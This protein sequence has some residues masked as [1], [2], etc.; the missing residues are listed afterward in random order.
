MTSRALRFLASLA[1]TLALAATAAA[2]DPGEARPVASS[3]A[4]A[5]SPCTTHLVQAGSVAEAR[6]AVA[7]RAQVAALGSDERATVP[8]ATRTATESAWRIR[9]YGRIA[10]PA[11]S[12]I[13]P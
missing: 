10:S 8:E 2:A 3:A 9:P 12:W 4:F 5:H 6:D 1:G 7:T 11:N 13:D